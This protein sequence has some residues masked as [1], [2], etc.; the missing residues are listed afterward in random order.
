MGKTVAFLSHRQVQKQGRIANLAG[1]LGRGLRAVFGEKLP[2]GESEIGLG[3]EAR[4]CRSS[5][6]SR[7]FLRRRNC[8]RL[9]SRSEPGFQIPALPQAGGES[10]GIRCRRRRRQQGELEDRQGRGEW[11]G[12]GKL[13]IVV[14]FL[15]GLWMTQSHLNGKERESPVEQVPVP[16]GLAAVSQ[17]ARRLIL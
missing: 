7:P 12:E 5:L 4:E 2:R 13:V 1:N 15:P 17:G 10:A 3:G 16:C 6:S 9:H 8:L 14:K 11:D